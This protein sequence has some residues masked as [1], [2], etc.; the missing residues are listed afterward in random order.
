MNVYK[1]YI[2]QEHSG[3][4]NRLLI[5]GNNESEVREVFMNASL[6]KNFWFI[7]SIKKCEKL[8]Y[9]GDTPEIIKE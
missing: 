2:E 5:S 8:V 4:R 9:T 3:Y 7:D 1:V 6:T